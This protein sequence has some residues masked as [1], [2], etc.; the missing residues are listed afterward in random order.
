MTGILHSHI[1]KKKNPPATD[2]E[3]DY[4]IGNQRNSR[5]NGSHEQFRAET[6]ETSRRQICR[7]PREVRSVAAASSSRNTGHIGGCTR[8]KA[9]LSPSWRCEPARRRCTE[10]SGG[11]GKAVAGCGSRRR[12][13]TE[14][15]AGERSI[16]RHE[17]E[18]CVRE[19]AAQTSTLR[20]SSS[21]SSN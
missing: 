17:T 7:E 15:Q 3:G 9:V 12:P 14:G 11:A 1:C 19:S 4:R 8:T 13:V 5:L 20:S 2:V 6:L 21:S 10:S 16:G 18:T